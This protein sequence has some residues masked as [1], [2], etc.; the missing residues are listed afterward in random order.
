MSLKIEMLQT[1]IAIAMR[2]R[3]ATSSQ[4]FDF[5]SFAFDA[6]RGF[7]RPGDFARRWSLPTFDL[8]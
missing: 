6:G 7:V 5:S 1:I 2:T 4:S 3:N 8:T